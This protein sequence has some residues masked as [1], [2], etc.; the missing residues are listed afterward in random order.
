MVFV[1]III[2]SLILLAAACAFCPL[3]TKWNP[4][5]YTEEEIEAKKRLSFAS[6]C[7]KRACKYKCLHCGNELLPDNNGRDVRCYECGH[8]WHPDYIL[9]VYE[10]ENL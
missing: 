4:K 5:F 2:G 7:I 1:Y 3:I 9:T 8:L 6:P 10:D